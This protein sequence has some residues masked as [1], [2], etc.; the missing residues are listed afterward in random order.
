[1][2]I[3]SKGIIAAASDAAL[4]RREIAL[5]AAA[6]V[7]NP[8]AWVEAH[9][10]RLTAAPISASAEENAQ[11]LAEVYVYAASEYE[12]KRNIAAAKLA[13]AQAALDELVPPGEDPLVVT[14]AHLQ[15]AVG[16]LVKALKEQ[17]GA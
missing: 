5:A 4:L 1:M 12:K 2:N 6:G 15:N 16:H 8:Q 13:E 10:H 11:S 7:D 17:L 3:T 14:D 9:R